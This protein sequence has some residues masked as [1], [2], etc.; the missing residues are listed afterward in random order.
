MSQYNRRDIEMAAPSEVGTEMTVGS[1]FRHGSIASEAGARSIYSDRHGRLNQRIENRMIMDA[2]PSS[3]DRADNS[4]NQL[5]TRATGAILALFGVLLMVVTAVVLST[6]CCGSN[7]KDDSNSDVC[8]KITD[9]SPIQNQGEDRNACYHRNIVA[10]VTAV[11]ALI[12][13]GFGTVVITVGEFMYDV[14]DDREEEKVQKFANHMR[15]L[16]MQQQEEARL[17]KIEAK[18]MRREERAYRREQ[19]ELE[20]MSNRSMDLERTRRMD[21]SRRYSIGNPQTPSDRMVV[22]SSPYVIGQAQPYNGQSDNEQ[23]YAGEQRNVYGRGRTGN[24]R[25]VV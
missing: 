11:F 10:C 7:F 14:N 23:Y 17:D 22:A 1:D 6:P 15:L 12:L 9:D 16:Q 5:C 20:K 25:A 19:R 18:E 13:L 8:A 24:P 21:L 2:L 4:C 3:V